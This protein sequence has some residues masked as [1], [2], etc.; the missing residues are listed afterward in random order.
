MASSG[1]FAGVFGWD[2]KRFGFPEG[3]SI[4]FEDG[5]ENGGQH[6]AQDKT[7]ESEDL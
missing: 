2:G 3:V 7:Q 6:K 5:D 1:G 4:E